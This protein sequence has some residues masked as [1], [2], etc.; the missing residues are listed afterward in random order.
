M[1]S[2]P[3]VWTQSSGGVYRTNYSNLENMTGIIA[4]TGALSITLEFTSFATE[5][6]Y[7][8]VTLK[9][10][11]A[12]GCVQ[13]SELGRFSGSTIPRPVTS[14]TG[15]MMIQWT[16][17]DSVIRPGWSAIWNSLLP[18]GTATTH[19]QL[20]PSTST[21]TLCHHMPWSPLSLA[22]PQPG[23]ADT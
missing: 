18:A 7:D 12:I 13:S 8:V 19:Y 11:T 14:N 4:P 20:Y 21:S 23:W 2:E 16:S 15:V 17:D 6:T 5:S 22:H 10:C 9:N 1:S 3:Q